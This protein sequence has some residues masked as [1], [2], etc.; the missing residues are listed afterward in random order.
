MGARK[1][2]NDTWI[3]ILN[4]VVLRPRLKPAARAAGVDPSSLFLKIKDSIAEPDKHMVE[5]LGTRA[6]F[7][8]HMNTARK[9][10][11]V[12]LDRAALEMALE[13]HSQPRYDAAGRPVWKTDPRAAADALAM[14]D[15]TFELVWGRPRTDVYLRDADGKLI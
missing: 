14:D 10:A 8:E 13:G 12:E 3:D 2:T 11:I 1:I 9:L 5:W 4:R 15:T 6:P 7:H